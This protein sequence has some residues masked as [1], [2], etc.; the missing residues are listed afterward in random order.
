MLTGTF[1]FKITPSGN[2]I[3]EYSHRNSPSRR[4]YAE[5]ATRI[6]HDSGW[7]GKYKTTWCEGEGPDFHTESA[8]LIISEPEGAVE[9]FTVRWHKSAQPDAEVMFNG[10]AMLCDGML[11]GDYNDL[12]T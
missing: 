1:Y 10:E 6:S 3:G 12:K 4:S 9:L 7:V 11:V 2:L 8:T 5:A